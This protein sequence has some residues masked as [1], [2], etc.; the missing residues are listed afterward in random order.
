MKAPPTIQESTYII[1]AV[2]FVL[3][4]MAPI[5]FIHKNR[6]LLFGMHKILV[7]SENPLLFRYSIVKELILINMPIINIVME[8][9][10]VYDYLNGRNIG[11]N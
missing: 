5:Y 2:V 11:K 1:S 4:M 10:T 8:S 7:T 6:T 9:L 3:A